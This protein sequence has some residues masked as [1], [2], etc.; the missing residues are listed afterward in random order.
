MDKHILGYSYNGIFSAIKRNGV[1]NTCSVWTNPKNIMLR[2]K[3][4][5]T[6][7]HTLYDSIYMKYPE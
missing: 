5:G 6:K 7:G 4:P 3:K 2:G 1:L